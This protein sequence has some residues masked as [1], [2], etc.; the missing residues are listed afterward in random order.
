MFRLPV[1]EDAELN[2]HLLRILRVLELEVVKEKGC[3]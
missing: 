3:F 1:R 2:A